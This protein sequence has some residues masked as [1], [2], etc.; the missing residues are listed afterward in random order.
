M[1]LFIRSLALF[2][3]SI[4]ITTASGQ[5]IVRPGTSLNLG[6]TDAT[7]LKSTGENK[8]VFLFVDFPDAPANEDAQQL[9]QALVPFSQSWYDEVSY[10]R[11][12][13]T[14][15]PVY[16]WF[17]MPRASTVYNFARGLTFDL[18]KQYIS[19]A[20]GAAD[21]MVD[22]S[23]FD[24][25]YV[26]ASKDSAVP[27][28][29]TWVPNPGQGIRVDG[30][31][32][33]HVV[34][35]GADTRLAIPLYKW[36]VI[37]HETGHLMGLPDLYLFAGNDVHAPAG[38]WDNMGLITVGAHY[39]SWQ[40]R[41]L[42][43]LNDDE[44]S[45]VT[46]ASAQVDLSPLE[47]SSGIRGL[48]VQ[49]GPSKALIAEVRRLTGKDAGLCDQGLLVY[50]VDSSIAS[51]GGPLAV[52]RAVPS[53]TDSAKI[54]ECGSPYN[55]T[56]NVGGG[57]P[58]TFRDT[59]SGVTFDILGQPAGGGMTVRVTNP[60]PVRFFPAITSVIG[61]GAFGASRIVAP[62]GWMEIF[63]RNFGSVSRSWGSHDFNGSQ[64]PNSL[65]GIRVTIGG[66]AAYVSYISPGQLNV[67][68][69]DGLAPGNAAVVVTNDGA[70]TDAFNVLVAGRAPGLLSPPNFSAG[71]KQYIAALFPD[72]TFVGPP[73]LIAGAPFR[74]AAAGDTLVLYGIGFGATTPAIPAGQIAGQANSLPGLVVRVGGVDARVAFAGLAQGFVGLY[75][76][77]VVVPSGV[78]GDVPLTMTISGQSV[79]QTLSLAL[80]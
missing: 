61:A 26:I 49:V 51:G 25:A 15:T 24:G 59:A 73:G 12:K 22:F 57:K 41:K 76:F 75:Q 63:G 31:Q 32:L 70:V 38:A 30:V 7:R 36:H 64:A 44:F 45:C 72:Q 53:G 65:D 74:R 67:Q 56:F 79:P 37:H 9:Y 16:R 55:A 1:N 48:A 6:A 77:N 19:D 42:G 40:K 18:H 50:T 14:V 21:S 2:L 58:S 46:A 10:G 11:M 78:S 43:W 17:R 33:R 23:Q 3:F 62:G 5:C 29:P 60:L 80:Q 71:G 13:L 66:V 28:S 69:P 20:V 47:S 4:C 54:A 27:F 35:L 68:I 52:Q 8:M 34:T 39:T